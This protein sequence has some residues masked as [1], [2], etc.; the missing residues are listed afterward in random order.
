[1]KLVCFFLVVTLGMAYIQLDAF[2]K[3]ESVRVRDRGI[4]GP[5]VGDRIEGEYK[6]GIG[7]K[8]RI[9]VMRNP[10]L[11]GTSVVN[12]DGKIAYPLLGM[13]D[14][15]GLT[16]GE[17]QKNLKEKLAVYIRYPEVTV[18]MESSP[19]KKVVVVGE[20]DEPDVYTYEGEIS[21]VDAIAL[22][23]DVT[24]DAK[25]ESIVVVSNN[26]SDKPVARR[27]NYFKALREGTTNKDFLLKPGDIIYV[28]RTFVADLTRFAGQI[29]AIIGGADSATAD[30][31]DYKS[32]IR[33]AYRGLFHT[34]KSGYDK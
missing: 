6:L 5:L 23:G 7:D 13:I 8:L 12:P 15:A 22:A 30:L 11:S 17:F 9:F 19:G 33:N 25:R 3:G 2:A 18:T 1:M 16:I 24:L 4:T 29:S 10:D 28:P 26:F 21:V 34:H 32:E 20:V 27:V 31:V 14:A